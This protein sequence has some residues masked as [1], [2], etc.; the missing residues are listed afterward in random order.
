MKNKD[1]TFILPAAGK[2]SRFK[3][4]KS[5]IFYKYKDK[6]LISHVLDKCL[7]FTNN[8]IIVSNKKNLKELKKNL[9][10]YKKTK[11]KIFIQGKPLGMGHAIDIALMKVKTKYSAVIWPDQIYLNENTIQK[12]INHFLKK[13]CILCFPVYKKKYPY[14]YVKNNSKNKFEDIIQTRETNKIKSK[15]ESDCGFFVFNTNLVRKNLKKLIKK[16]LIITNKTK[17]IDFLQSFK[18]LNKISPIETV[19]ATNLKDTIGVNILK[20][21]M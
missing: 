19:R 2:S 5:K 13:K 16:K 12:T 10:K 20:D 4:K 21:L 1:F 9:L 3:S 15:G 6:I 8:I 18:Y 11:I 7:N 14:V 17:E